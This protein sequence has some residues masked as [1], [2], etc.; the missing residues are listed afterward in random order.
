MSSIE[1]SGDG[2]TV[3]VHTRSTTY[4]L[5]IDAAAG[6]LRPVHWGSRLDLA[7]AR[8]LPA[9]PSAH[10][11]TFEAP[12]EAAE[13][14]PA[15]GSR[16]FGA[17]ALGGWFPDGSAD[18]ELTV[19]DQRV[20]G[21]Q[22]TV[23]LTDTRQPLAVDLH[24]RPVAGTDV[25]ERWAVLHHTG[26]AGIID[27]HRYDAGA[28]CVPPRDDYRISHVTG[29]WSAEGL[30]HRTALPVAETHFT[31]RRGV[32]GHHANPWVM[33]DDGTARE[34][35][36]EVWSMALAH[37]GSWRITASR[38]HAGRCAVLGGAG[39]EGVRHRLG[40]GEAFTTPVFAGLYTGGGF[41]AASRGW[42]AYQR[43]HV[44][45]HASELR[46]VL[47]NSWEATTFDVTQ[48]GQLALARLAADL[49]AELFVV[50][51]GWFGARTS[52]RAGLGDWT[53]NPHRFRDGL[54]PVAEE[55]RGLGMGFGIWV[56]PE[57][58]NPDSDLYRTHPDWV[59]HTP[60]HR[61][62]ELRN[63]LVLDFGRAD[64]REWAWQ[65]LDGLVR[66]T[67]AALLKWDFNRPITEAAQDAW[68]GHARGVYAV[69]DRLRAAH[70]QLRIESCAGGGGRVDLG[71]MAR[72]D[73]FWTSDNTDAVDRLTIQ[74]GHTQ[75]YAP[76]SM[77]AWVTDSPNPLT[78][79]VVPL[80]FRFH[81]AMTGTLGIGG[82]LTTWDT[83]ELANARRLVAQYKDIR[84]VVQHGELYRLRDPRETVSAVQYLHGD[85]VVVFIFQVGAQFAAPLRSLP[86]AGLDPTATYRDDDTGDV[87]GGATLAG[88]GLPVR[89]P[90]GDYASALVR[91]TRLRT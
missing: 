17:A 85:R 62:T 72:T 51:D 20:D 42:H 2:A 44:V 56:E 31:S 75:L 88:P 61:R 40:P 47:Y 67:G 16:R 90:G 79:R 83:G 77:V 73:Q 21:D 84:P 38:S 46:P 18:C 65:W 50:D 27:L 74:H 71:I 5:H 59:H 69:V 78:E 9:R 13:D 37:S 7:A 81:V 26:D 15:Q 82:D 64:V 36:G 32:T 49:G 12:W 60:G 6:S 53:P 24:Y 34:E 43:G 89:L 25:I 8:A 22:L 39:H 54:G 11:D 23:M 52:D 70:P 55:I 86:L 58:T 87:Y 1:M 80:P 68:T 91:L 10:T 4:A 63:Q 3:A 30:V 29:A 19:V 41:G 14:Y 48:E 28:W 35:H 33:V 66:D 45:P 57:M 76:R